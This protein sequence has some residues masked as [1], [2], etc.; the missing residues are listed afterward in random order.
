MNKG[1]LRTSKNTEGRKKD[2]GGGSQ[3]GRNEKNEGNRGSQWSLPQAE[4]M[5]EQL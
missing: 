2:R 1:N 4:M 5:N 3:K